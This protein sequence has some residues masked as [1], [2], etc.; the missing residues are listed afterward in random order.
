MEAQIR[1]R[2]ELIRKTEQEKFDLESD[3]QK[4]KYEQQIAKLQ[5]AVDNLKKV[6]CNI[7]K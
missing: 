7:M 2:E 5:E 4:E 1:T 3:K 6:C